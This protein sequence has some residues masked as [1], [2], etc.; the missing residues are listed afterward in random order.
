MKTELLEGP[1]VGFYL[2][3]DRL[4]TADQR[5]LPGELRYG[6]I[7][8]FDDAC[9]AVLSLSVRGAPAI[10][11]VC[12]HALFLELKKIAAHL[13]P[14]DSATQI[15]PDLKRLADGFLKTRP[16]AVNLANAMSL[17]LEAS[18]RETTVGGVLRAVRETSDL[19]RQTDQKIC[20]DLGSY[21]SELIGQGAK[22]LTH[23]N[24]G[25]LATAGIGTA[26]GAFYTAQAQGKNIT[27]YA[28]ETRPLLQGARLTSW[29]LDRAGI[30]TILL[31]D[32][33]AAHAM[34]R[35]LIDLVML[36]ADR[37]VRNGDTANKIGT[38]SLAVLAS[39]FRIPFYVVAPS[40]TLDP[41]TEEGKDIHI[42]E[43]NP[44]EVRMFAGAR[45]A[46]P[47]IPVLN[48]AFD[49]TP[50]SLITAIITEK[51]I[52]RPPYNFSL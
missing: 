44:D 29:E 28:T 26:I 46:P 42:E 10:A 7:T 50:A 34:Q 41:F 21:A 20:A 45:S 25:A 37:I 13:S 30:R 22:I 4:F 9:Q 39:H 19:I 31:T 15:L 38:L 27:V 48:P 35:G 32:S 3:G 11:M 2:E 43:R 1:A 17:L 40:T 12:S 52:H 5:L 24:T 14:S 23:C 36:G 18:G 8:G 47:E 16:T 33:M 49:V 51:G 6:E